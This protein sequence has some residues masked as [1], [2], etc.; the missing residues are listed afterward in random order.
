MYFVFQKRS[1]KVKLDY[2]SEISISQER[3]YDKLSEDSSSF[4]ENEASKG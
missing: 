3:G 2:L 1:F 4:P